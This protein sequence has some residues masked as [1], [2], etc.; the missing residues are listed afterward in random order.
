[1]LIKELIYSSNSSWLTAFASSIGVIGISI[2]LSLSNGFDKQVDKYEKNTFSSFPITISKSSM[3]MNES[4]MEN[5]M[6]AVMPGEEDYPED[7]II[8]PFDLSS[9]DLLHTN[10]LNRDYIEYIEG[11]DDTLISGIS[12]T[13]ATGLNLLVKYDDSVKSVSTSDLSMGVIP[14]ELDN[15]DFMS[16]AFDLL[17]GKIPTEI[18][19]LVLV[20]DNKNRVDAKILKTL[21]IDYDKEKIDFSEIIGK[22]IK[23]VFNNDYYTSFRGMYIPNIDYE[24]VYDS[25][26]NL[27]LKIVG[28]VRSKED[29]YLGQ[30]ATS[31][32]SIGNITDTKSMMSTTNIG[33]IL[34][35]NNLVEKVISVNSTSDIV[36]AQEKLDVNIMTGEVLNE[37][38]KHNMMIYL[39]SEDDPYLVSIYPKD[40]NSKDKIIEYLDKYN[41]GKSDDEKIV[42]NDLASTFVTFG[43]K[44]MDAITIVLVS[45]SAVSL[46]V[47]S[48][49]I[50][51]ITY[52]SVLERTKEIGILRAL[53]AR[54]KDISRVFNAETLIVGILSG[55]IG[56]L[57]A[58]LLVF[59]IN[60]VLEDLTGLKTVAI[61]NPWHALL[62]IV[63]STLLTLIG[64]SIPARMASK[65]DP[66]IALRTE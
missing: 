47:S 45:F 65:K 9:Y 53:G 57:I 7:K 21:G 15:E 12:Y 61:L 42:Y 13:R 20:V 34:Y 4:Q 55:L 30:I 62:L 25:E 39:G 40:F 27:T 52:I 6:G 44:V 2:I 41:E 17:E 26:N 14:K 43:S 49:M 11:L 3:Q 66:V 46:I 10:N 18:T 1:M 36:E 58:R 16:E 51:I 31:V 32:N 50:G 37:E 35:R 38:D 5:L 54:K 63:V 8:F 24:D 33:N 64:G 22:E 48:I 60:M 56:V 29:N 19:D 28:I 59:P 23:L